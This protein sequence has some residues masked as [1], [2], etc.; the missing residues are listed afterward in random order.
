MVHN[1]GRHAEADWIFA[2]EFAQVRLSKD[3]NGNSARLKVEDL[4]SGKSICLDPLILA[5]LVWASDEALAAHTDPDL[6]HQA[7]QS[8]M[9][10][11]DR[12]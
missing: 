9:R 7:M 2:N 5:S 11:A 8:A 10:L 1:M 6:L 12:R 3:R 4:Q